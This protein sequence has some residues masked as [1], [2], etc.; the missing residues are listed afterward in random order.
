MFAGI[1]EEAGTG[2]TVLT[3]GTDTGKQ[4]QHALLSLVRRSVAEESDLLS[5][6]VRCAK[7]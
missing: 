5:W 6:C 4:Q 2:T 3:P 7:F 1:A